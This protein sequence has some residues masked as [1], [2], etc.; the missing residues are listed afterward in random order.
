MGKSCESPADLNIPNLCVQTPEQTNNQ[1]P[2]C[3]AFQ[4]SFGGLGGQGES[5]VWQYLCSSLT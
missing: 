5:A 1:P 2:E 4:I 3:I